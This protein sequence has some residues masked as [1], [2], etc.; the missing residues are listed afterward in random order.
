MHLLTNII[1]GPLSWFSDGGGPLAWAG[2]EIIKNILNTICQWIISSALQTY[3]WMLSWVLSNS[4]LGMRQWWAIIP[5]INNVSGLMG[6]VSLIPAAIG[7][8]K[9]AFKGSLGD[10]LRSLFWLIISFPVT[11]V[12][13]WMGIVLSNGA[14]T[15][16]IK[17][18]HSPV[19]GGWV[20][21]SN[22][23]GDLQK[24]TYLLALTALLVIIL[25][26][27]I[28]FVIL[29]VL[30][31]NLVVL[32]LAAAAP[33]A[34]MSQSDPAMRPFFKKWLYTYIGAILYLPFM[35]FI[36]YVSQ[37]IMNTS[38]STAA[39]GTGLIGCLMA[40]FSPWVLIKWVSQITP[41]ES[42]A[43]LV[44]EA[45][46]HGTSAAKRVGK[47]VLEIGTA[48]LTGGASLLAGAGAAGVTGAAKSLGA[49]GKA[50]KAGAG[51][52]KGAAAKGSTSKA[53]ASKS[54]TSGSSSTS[55][56]TSSGKSSSTTQSQTNSKSGTHLAN[57]PTFAQKVSKVASNIAQGAHHLDEAKKHNSMG[58]IARAA[59]ATSDIADHFS[60]NKATP[61]QEESS[62]EA[63]TSQ[64]MGQNTTENQNVDSNKKV[65][66]N[67]SD[68]DMG[69]N[70]GFTK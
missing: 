1:G 52:V 15:L 35:A 56:S 5:S 32:L 31:R 61:D 2:G 49:A 30:M 34:L 59:Q 44:G 58:N 37:N 13:L 36:L 47:A 50:G 7:V 10:V 4:S 67:N 17:I 33:L 3:N 45:A 54:G 6:F 39:V 41:F 21:N 20:A 69:G 25:F 40:V 9:G 64:Q 27:G 8:I 66:V 60:G 22:S 26:V 12:S 42:G 16:T 51:A 29:A 18:L 28:I 11:V 65:A 48:A 24:D 14:N 57:K 63:T 53:G 23:F 70:Y 55:T 68:E 46:A 38:V 19:T 62:N 43:N